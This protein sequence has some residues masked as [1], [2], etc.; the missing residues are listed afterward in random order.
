MTLAHALQE[1]KRLENAL[2]DLQRV[3]ESLVGTAR[4]EG[5]ASGGV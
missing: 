3:I 5:D 4:P 1:E 2:L